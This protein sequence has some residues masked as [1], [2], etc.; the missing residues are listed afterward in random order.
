M[1]VEFNK[2]LQRSK[3][4]DPRKDYQERSLIL[5]TR[6]DPLTKRTVRV[7]D[8]AI[9]R[10]DKLNMEEFLLR[11][12]D[13]KCPFCP[14][15]LEELTPKFADAFIEGGRLRFGEVCVVPNRLPFDKFCGVAVLTK[16]HYV[17]L[18]GFTEELLFDGF[19]T[20]QVFLRRVL[21]VDPTL[22]FFSVNWNYLPM[23]GGS[24]IHPH[25]QIIGG[26]LP[27]NYQWEMI[28][29]GRE[30]QQRWGKVF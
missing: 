12:K 27:T 22:V 29:R 2:K 7:L 28:Q 11:A 19:S 14:D 16:K 26:E 1:G 4:L 13:V 5:E 10:L 21:E 9:K 18:L 25:L 3:I 24:V 15:S 30:Y 8:L 20:A 6:W 17:P 23:S